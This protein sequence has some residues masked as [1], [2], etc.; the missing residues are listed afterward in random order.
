MFS[1]ATLFGAGEGSQDEM[2]YG[3]S[4]LLSDIKTA[5]GG[6]SGGNT[7][8]NNITVNGAENPEEWASRFAR[9]LKMEVRMA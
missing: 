9:Q 2:L 4:N 7:F 1:N 5:V 8:T 6:A 3:R